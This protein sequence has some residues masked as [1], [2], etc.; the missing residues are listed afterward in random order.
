MIRRPP[1]ST[2]F[3]YTTLFRSVPNPTPRTRPASSTVATAVFDD[4]HVVVTPVTT[5]FAASR[6]VAV[7]ARVPP[8]AGVGGGALTLPVDPVGGV[9]VTVNEPTTAEVRL[10][11]EACKDAL[12]AD[13]A[14]IVAVP[15]PTAV[16][17]PLADTAATA[18]FD[19]DH[20]TGTSVATAFVT[21]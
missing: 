14:V 9:M 10:L 1:R 3:P 15:G 4:V 12:V 5:L 19:D 16:S 20:T 11:V 17:M 8:A 2:L 13:V 7:S 6:A 21:A 18:G